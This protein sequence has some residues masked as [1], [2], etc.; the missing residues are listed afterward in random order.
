MKIK[1][2]EVVS[3]LFESKTGLRWKIGVIRW[4]H[5]NSEN[6]ID[7]GIMT[8]SQSAVPIAV[9]AVDDGFGP[10]GHLNRE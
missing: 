10:A 7:M 9:K 5:I 1:V 3:Y 6:N 4:V 2:G 8:L